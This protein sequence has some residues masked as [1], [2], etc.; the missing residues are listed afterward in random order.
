MY[1]IRSYYEGR[2]LD[3]VETRVQLLRPRGHGLVGV[4]DAV[5][6]QLEA[7]RDVVVDL[8]SHLR[9]VGRNNFV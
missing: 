2:Q 9:Q 1:A 8:L 4:R 7:E 5:D 3:A 6:G